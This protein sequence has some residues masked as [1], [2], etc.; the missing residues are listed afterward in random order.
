MKVHEEKYI[1]GIKVETTKIE[2]PM[3]DIIK[4]LTKEEWDWLEMDPK[5]VENYRFEKPKEWDPPK[6]PR[7]EWR[8]RETQDQAKEEDTQ[9]SI[10]K[11]NLQPK[12]HSEPKTSKS[13]LGSGEEVGTTGPA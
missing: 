7:P 9:A 1:L 12:I 11:E 8:I 2:S 3:E 13:R 6:D 4:N 5:V 10:R